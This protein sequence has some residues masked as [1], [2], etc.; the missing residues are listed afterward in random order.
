MWRFFDF[1][2]W[3]PLPSYDAKFCRNRSNRGRDMTSF[4]FFKMVAAAILEFLNLKLLTVG[5]LER[6]DLRRRAKF[7]RNHSDCG[8]DMAIFQFFQDG[9]R[10]PSWICYVCVWTTHEGHLVVFITV[11]NLVGMD[12][13]VLI[14]CMFFDLSSLSTL[15]NWGFW[16]FDTLNG[17]AYQRNPKMHILGQKDFIWRIDCQNRSTGATCVRD[18]GTKRRKKDI[19]RNPTVANWVFAETTHVVG[20]K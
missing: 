9:G 13:V 11:Q 14:I 16:G 17:E 5:Q 3:R 18:E 10:P 12:A 20:S 8:Q 19:D 6:V 1:S 15:Q 4:R 2:R 7:C